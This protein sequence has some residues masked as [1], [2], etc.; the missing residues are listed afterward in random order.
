MVEFVQYNHEEH[1]EQFFELNVE[2]IT[3][4][5]EQRFKNVG[6]KL[7]DNPREYVV[8]V[9]P[10]FASIKPPE[11]IIY[12]LMEE[13]KAVGMGA[14]RKLEDGVGEV[15]R[16][17]IQPGHRGKGYGRLMM[18]GL[19]DEARR[20]GYHM[21]RLDTAY[22]LEVAVHLY[23]SVGFRERDKY[24]GTESEGTVHTIYMERN[25]Q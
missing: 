12:L 18:N 16:M 25:L 1:K 8:S 5:N 22:Y 24:P 2:Y 10:K 19:I 14:L 13:G 9:F 21:L 7:L 20:L 11:G 15:K 23:R 6:A 3:Y 4:L 17:F